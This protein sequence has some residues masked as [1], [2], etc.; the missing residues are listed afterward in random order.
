[1]PLGAVFRVF[2]GIFLYQR[3]HLCSHYNITLP[4]FQPIIFPFFLI[5]LAIWL[6]FFGKYDKIWEN[7]YFLGVQY[8]STDLQTEG[9]PQ[10][11]RLSYPPLYGYEALASLP[12][13]HR[14]YAYGERGRY[15]RYQRHRVLFPDL[16][17]H[18][19][20]LP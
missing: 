9:F 19:D 6:I 8:G 17:L 1:M 7:V 16:R 14:N 15:T 5:F 11:Q 12:R 20:G 18:R 3:L 13:L 4:D 10:R 2:S